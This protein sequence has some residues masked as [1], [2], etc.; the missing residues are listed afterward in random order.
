MTIPNNSNQ[1]L[2]GNIAIP[3]ALEIQSITNANP[4]VVTATLDMV[5]QSN[6]YIVGQLVR[7]F[8]P[9]SY[10][11]WQANGLVGQI[12]AVDGLVFTLAIDSINFDVFS[13]PSPDLQGP[14]SFS[15]AGSR[16]LQYSN[17]TNSLGFQ[18][19]NDRGN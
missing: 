19:L 10:G 18:S 12:L 13:I 5:T 4:M 2:P 8:V 9:Y 3:S 16:N 15:P 1:Y 14:A 17:N 6:S 11:M 7:L